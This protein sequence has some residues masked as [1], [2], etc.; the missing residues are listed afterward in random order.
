MKLKLVEYLNWA[1]FWNN[2]CFAEK[3]T[4]RSSILLLCLVT[5][6]SQKL[7]WNNLTFCNNF[8]WKIFYFFRIII[9][10]IGLIILDPA[11]GV[12]AENCLPNEID[13]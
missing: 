5:L 4:K 8:G 7:I 12:L 2:V 6:R 10:T 11:R 3:V 9:L 1:T 13:S